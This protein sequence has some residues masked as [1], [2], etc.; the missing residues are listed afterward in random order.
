MTTGSKIAIVLITLAAVSLGTGLVVLISG[1]QTPDAVPRADIDLEEVGKL[2]ESDVR[3]LAELP[4]LAQ[5]INE[6]QL[7]EGEEKI[8]VTQLADC[9]V[10]GWVDKDNDNQPDTR[11]SPDEAGQIDPEQ[12]PDTPEVVF[13][14]RA[15]R[16]GQRLVLADRYHTMAE[17]KVSDAFASTETWRELLACQQ[18]YYGEGRHWRAPMFWVFMPYGY[19]GGWSSARSASLGRRAGSGG[20][21]G[22]K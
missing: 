13:R 15:E 4:T 17:H 11:Y 8:Q 9:S 12:P 3:S 1:A 6:K 22:G 5:K 20:I 16:K 7:Y 19:Y 10:L 18:R 14:L 21:G 2:F